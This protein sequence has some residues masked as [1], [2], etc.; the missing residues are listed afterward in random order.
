MHFLGKNLKYLRKKLGKT[1]PEIASLVNKGSTTVSNWENGE[2]EPSLSELMIISNFFGVPIDA[3]LNKDLT[4][5][6]DAEVVPGDNAIWKTIKA[7]Q[8]DIGDIKK[9]LKLKS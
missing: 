1:Q 2:S 7:L 6:Q 5:T 8:K 9:A 3:L 4:T